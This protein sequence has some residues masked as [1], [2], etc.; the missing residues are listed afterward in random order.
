MLLVGVLKYHSRWLQRNCC[1]GSD[2]NLSPRFL[3]LRMPVKNIPVTTQKASKRGPVDLETGSPS[4]LADLTMSHRWPVM[5][6]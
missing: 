3:G 2:I 1:L 4:S 6:S 5:G